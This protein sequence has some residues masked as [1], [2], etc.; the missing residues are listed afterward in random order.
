[1][2]TG[3]YS[4]ITIF[5]GI[6]SLLSIILTIFEH[7]SAKL[8]LNTETVLIVKMSV[9]CPEISSMSSK[10]FK[11]IQNLRQQITI[12][13]AKIVDIDRRLIELLRPIQTKH[14]V[15]LTFHIRSDSS[16]SATVLQLIRKEVRS[17]YLADKLFEIWAI[18]GVTKRPKILNVE[19]KEL[20]PDRDRHGDNNN[21]AAV[22]SMNSHWDKQFSKPN[23]ATD[24]N[25]L[26]T[27][28][29]FE[30]DNGGLVYG[31]NMDINES[32]DGEQMSHNGKYNYKKSNGMPHHMNPPKVLA[33]ASN[34][35]FSYVSGKNS[36]NGQM[37]ENDNNDRG[38]TANEMR[39]ADE[40]MMDNGY[41]E[42]IKADSMSRK[43]KK[44]YSQGTSV[45][46]DE[47]ERS[48][49][50]F[51]DPDPMEALETIGGVDVHNAFGQR[52]ELPQQASVDLDGL[53][54]NKQVSQQNEGARPETG[55]SVI[56]IN[57]N[58][59]EGAD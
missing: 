55:G 6:F 14:G 40:L 57:M 9:M 37:N 53:Y 47:A 20:I 32:S 51:S 5:S 13:L 23:L 1:M 16:H 39:L 38:L 54:M 2:S 8:L 28:G 15:Y 42:N 19:T 17:K 26:E 44:K 50:S 49:D 43:G 18:C 3:T 29:I 27:N 10:R 25:T 46:N 56:H 58:Q 7:V 52:G 22:I 33:I 48:D 41:Q 31:D 11:E 12:E 21:V 59:T 34:E 24:T 30:T 36:V 35:S 45:G 4:P